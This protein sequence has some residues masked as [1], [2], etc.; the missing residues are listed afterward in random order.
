MNNTELTIING[1]LDKIENIADVKITRGGNEQNENQSFDFFIDVVDKEGRTA[2]YAV[3]TKKSVPGSLAESLLHKLN[4]ISQPTK[5]RHII[6]T[7]YISMD[8]AKKLKEQGIEFAD[9][10]GNMHMNLPWLKILVMGNPKEK[11]FERQTSLSSA[12][13]LKVIYTILTQP[14]SITWTHRETAKAAGV[15]LGSVT[16]VYRE[17]RSQGYLHTTESNKEINREVL[18]K[19]KLFDKWIAGYEDKLRQKLYLGSYRIAGNKPI[20][21]LPAM[22]V[23]TQQD[24]VLIGG[25][26]GATLLEK[27]NL[28]PG[29]ATLHLDENSDAKQL[30]L[31]LRMIPDAH[32]NVVF[33]QKFGAYNSMSEQNCPFPLT[34]PLLMYSE[35]L[36]INDPRVREFAELFFQSRI[37][38]IYNQ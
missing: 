11:Q 27:G 30:S 26:L 8:I 4:T 36:Q 31:Q 23:N 6:L 13:A 2:R 9:C 37:N 24:Q 17:L 10:A 19:A 35:L 21:D 15:A 7:E 34:D 3:Q 12:V 20:G 28:R 1:C 16:T 14:K 33:L 29:S 32:G 5:T 18:N 22:L 38:G 25:E